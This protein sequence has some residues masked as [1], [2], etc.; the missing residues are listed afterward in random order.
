MISFHKYIFTFL[1]GET[2][3]WSVFWQFKLKSVFG[4][5]IMGLGLADT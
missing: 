4:N 5:V 1:N 3:L 2:F